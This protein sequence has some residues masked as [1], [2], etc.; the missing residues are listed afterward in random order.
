M[1]NDGERKGPEGRDVGR[2]ASGVERGLRPRRLGP[3]QQQL[4]PLQVQAFG[5]GR[6]PRASGRLCALPPRAYASACWRLA[7]HDDRPPVTA[8]HDTAVLETGA[9]FEPATSEVAARRSSPELLF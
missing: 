8:L 4:R 5:P 1:N 9:G 2:R 7:D 3:S 6:Y